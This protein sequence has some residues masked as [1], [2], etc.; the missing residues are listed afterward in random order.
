MS[1]EDCRVLLARGFL[2]GTS[3]GNAPTGNG[4]TIAIYD[5]TLTTISRGLKG[6]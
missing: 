4:A 5:S 1:Q 3:G 2:L 6:K